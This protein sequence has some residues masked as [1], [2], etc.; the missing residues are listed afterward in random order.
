MQKMEEQN[1]A[2]V[3]SKRLREPEECP[4][5][6]SNRQSSD[7]DEVTFRNKHLFLK[8]L[9]MLTYNLCPCI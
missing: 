7:Y 3:K 2:L 5:G 8:A 9:K 4:S 6:T 1:D